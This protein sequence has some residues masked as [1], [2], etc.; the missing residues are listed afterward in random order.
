MEAYKGNALVSIFKSMEVLCEFPDQVIVL[1]GTSVVCGLNGRSAGLQQRFIDHAATV[2]FS[3][4]VRALLAAKNGDAR[5][6]KSILA[7]GAEATAHMEKMLLDAKTTGEAMIEV[8]KLYS[9]EERAA[10]RDGGEFPAGMVEK[11]VKNVMHIAAMLF[12]NHPNAGTLPHYKHLPNTF[13]F[14]SSLCMY[15]LALDWAVRGG[16]QN[17]SA[18]KLR[19]DTVDMNFVT[20]AT[21]FDGLLTADAK[22]ARLHREARIWL[23][24]LFGCQLPG[25]ISA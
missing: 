22:T 7:H 8:A 18:A 14:R 23:S 21:Y 2:D 13:I 19:N 25:G 3:K 9:K 5:Y 4:Y 6:V 15:L 17:V 24:A 16:V 11:I 12:Q 10:F 20:F 1:K